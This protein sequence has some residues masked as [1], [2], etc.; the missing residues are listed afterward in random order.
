M[1]KI[2]KAKTK[3]QNQEG[4]MN[5]QFLDYYTQRLKI[6]LH[7][8]ADASFV[9]Q[10]YEQFRKT[11]KEMVKVRVL[12]TQVP[13]IKHAINKTEKI[14]KKTLQRKKYRLNTLTRTSTSNSA[15]KHSF[16]EVITT[17]RSPGRI[18]INL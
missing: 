16:D 13:T 1:R 10:N 8:G 18:N 14:G 17:H 3:D 11:I 5:E 9:Q 4:L 15:L 2:L 6:N 7:Q 12:R